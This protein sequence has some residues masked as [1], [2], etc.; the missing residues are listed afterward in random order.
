MTTRVRDFVWIKQPFSHVKYGFRGSTRIDSRGHDLKATPQ[1]YSTDGGIEMHFKDELP[2]AAHS[3]R[4]RR[5]P[6]SNVTVSTDPSQQK[7]KSSRI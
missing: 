5:D 2:K 3:M 4:L 1:M 6:S 7:Q